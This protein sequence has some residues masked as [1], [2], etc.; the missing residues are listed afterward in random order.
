LARLARD[1]FADAS[2]S[3]VRTLGE[4]RKQSWRIPPRTLE[5]WED[6]LAAAGRLP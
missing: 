1:G 6:L 3:A 5:A 4:H 2:A